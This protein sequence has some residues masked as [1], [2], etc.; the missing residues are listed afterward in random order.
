MR[1][2]HHVLLKYCHENAEM[3]K[4]K[5]DDVILQ[6]SISMTACILSVPIVFFQTSGRFT[7][8]QNSLT[9]SEVRQSDAGYYTCKA[10]NEWGE[11]TASALL[12]V[13]DPSQ[14]VVLTRTPTDQSVAVGARATFSCEAA[15]T[16]TPRITW[17]KVL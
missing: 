12:T 11:N 14:Q 2:F 1:V 17:N 7:S 13:T 3:Q 5:F 10:I 9:I 15:G 6:Y 8:T 4:R 16:P